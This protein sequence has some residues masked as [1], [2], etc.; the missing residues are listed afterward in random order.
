MECDA[1]SQIGEGMYNSGEEEEI[2][3]E[4]GGRTYTII[5]RGYMAQG[6]DGYEVLLGKKHRVEEGEGQ[7]MSTILRRYL[8]VRFTPFQPS[9]QPTV[10]VFREPDT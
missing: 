7:M 3:R 9:P 5:T 4:K 6:H 1:R 8:L 10:D 2:K